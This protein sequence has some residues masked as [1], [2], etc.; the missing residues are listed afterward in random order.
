M[1]DALVMYLC[2]VC[3]TEFSSIVVL[4]YHLRRHESAGELIM[5]VRCNQDTCTSCFKTLWNLR[6]HMENYHKVHSKLQHVSK[7]LKIVSQNEMAVDTHSGALCDPQVPK[8]T[9]QDIQQEGVSLVA[10]LRSNSGLP[11]NIIPQIVNSFNQMTDCTVS[12][13]KQEILGS[14]KVMPNVSP[15]TLTQV[16]ASLDS[17][18][19]PLSFLA[20]RYKQDNYFVR[21]PLFVSSETLPIGCRYE[22]RGSENRLVYETYEY[23]SV[24]QNIRSLLQNK[25][26]VELIVAENVDPDILSS[27]KDGERYKQHYLFTDKSKF[28]IMIQLF[29]DGMGTTNPLRGQSATGNVG[30]FYYTI[31]NVPPSHNSCFANV[32]LLAL[33]YTEDLKRCGYDAILER[34]VSEM[35]K[36]QSVGFSGDFPVIGSSQVYVGLCQVACDNLALNGLFGFIECF[37][38]NYFCTL[39]L[40]TKQEIQTKTYE[41][42]FQ[43][44]DITNYNCDVKA[45]KALPAGGHIHGVKKPCCLNE[46]PGFHAV[47]NFVIDP[48]H[49]LLEGVVSFELSCILFEL[50]M[51]KRYFSLGDLNVN[52]HQFFDRNTTDKSKRPPTLNP[53]E[54][55][56]SKLSPSMKAT[57]MWSLLKYLPIF[58]A[59]CV[60]E[61]DKHW[62]FLL[63]LSELVDLIFA[64]K[65]TNGMI[66][67]LQ[68]VISDHLLDFQEL[69]GHEVKLRPK[70]HFLV[71]FPTIIRKNGPL[72]GMSCLRYEMKNSFFKRSAGVMCNFTN[73]CKTLAYRHQCNAFYLRSSKQYLR[74]NVLV[75][76]KQS[77]FRT[78]KEVAFCACLCE[79][80]GVDKEQNVCLSS[81]LV[82]ASESYRKG[83][84]FVVGR[85]E[86]GDPLFGEV[87]S[88]SS[89]PYSAAW[90]VIVLI[91]TTVRFQCHVHAYEVKRSSISEY[92]CIALANLID[93]T[94]LFA[95]NLSSPTARESRS[96]IRL[97][98]HI[99]I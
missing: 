71:H 39:C 63:G 64:P 35:L 5:P 65:F 7:N 52:M 59:H 36:L 14:L 41:S 66:A 34:F 73:V 67:Y 86:N 94:P 37:S 48:M 89:L 13:L 99:I 83:Q 42:E 62:L 88:F 51:V 75:G 81:R 95:Y 97:P 46:I 38:S 77:E 47:D 69:Y 44:R 28:S 27:F 9:L 24:E 17:V 55:K 20:S 80:L 58:M 22:R 70:H 72:T 90:F 74:T 8:L 96:L 25:D 78:P 21:H 12:Y 3:K 15:D 16:E 31:Q 23:V 92:R 68:E 82:V 54:K 61:G 4:H 10:S 53:V 57:Q 98:Y 76:C 45:A 91:Y 79:S 50:M 49:T 85:G 93:H 18:H 1:A 56:G 11:H 2:Y 19:Q 33:C 84:F 26:F 30:V 6:R 43:M 32:H 87:Q 29:Y 60:P 40:A